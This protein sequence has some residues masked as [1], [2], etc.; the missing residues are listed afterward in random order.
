MLNV[1]MQ[2]M[3]EVKG[4]TKAAQVMIDE[5]ECGRKKSELEAAWKV[6]GDILWK[7]GYYANS[8][9]RVKMPTYPTLE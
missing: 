3:E 7:A 2:R 6:I 5:M 4:I 1:A 9:A 8:I